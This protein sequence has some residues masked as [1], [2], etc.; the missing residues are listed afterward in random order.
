MYIAIISSLG[1]WRNITGG[2]GPPPASAPLTTPEGTAMIIIPTA[3]TP[4]TK[5]GVDAAMAP[6]EDPPARVFT[7][8]ASCSRHSTG[9]TGVKV[10]ARGMP[11]REWPAHQGRRAAAP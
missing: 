1:M 7:N 3:A 4:L 8:E 6:P 9:R 10:A 5:C 11:P 2:Y